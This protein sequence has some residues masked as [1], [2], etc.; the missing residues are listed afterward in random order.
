MLLKIHFLWTKR[1][2]LRDPRPNQFASQ[3]LQQLRQPGQDESQPSTSAVKL[4]AF[5]ANAKTLLMP[6]KSKPFNE[7]FLKKM[8]SL[9]YKTPKSRRQAEK[10][11]SENNTNE[12]RV[13][14][15]ETLLI[16]TLPTAIT[17]N[18]LLQSLYNQ[19]IGYLAYNNFKDIQSVYRLSKFSMLTF[20]HSEAYARLLCGGETKFSD[21]GLCTPAQKHFS[22]MFNKVFNVEILTEPDDQKGYPFDHFEPLLEDKEKAAKK[23]LEEAGIHS[24]CL[25]P[26]L[27]GPRDESE[28]YTSLGVKGNDIVEL[29]YWMEFTSSLRKS[30]KCDDELKERLG[31]IDGPI[32]EN[33]RKVVDIQPIDF[34]KAFPKV[35]GIMHHNQAIKEKCQS[36]NNKITGKEHVN[37][38]D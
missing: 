18:S 34:L 7:N 24:D 30:K 23:K 35:Q 26:V 3:Y 2:D 15:P 11:Q 16:G 32:F 27:F 19:W 33:D 14:R 10:N 22:F 38:V 25:Y 31:N 29:H 9:P 37:I 4:L 20:L 36:F 8:F 21:L 17:Q 13:K 12:Y 5:N 6:S 1:R 28:I